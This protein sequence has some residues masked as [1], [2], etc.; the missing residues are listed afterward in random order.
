[1]SNGR[2]DPTVGPLIKVWKINE[3]HPEVP[4]A[5]DVASAVRLVNWRD[6]VV[7]DAAKTAFLKRPLGGCSRNLAGS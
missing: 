4:N 5:A 1:M 3:D 2:F 6:V 7:D